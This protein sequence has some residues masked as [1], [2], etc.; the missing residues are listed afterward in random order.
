MT[1]NPANVFGPV[2]ADQSATAIIEPRALIRS[3]TCWMIPPSS[4][5]KLHLKF[6]RRADRR[7]CAP[8]QPDVTA[9]YTCSNTP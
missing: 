8:R 6:A 3:P 7:G 9:A 1:F 4:Y 5:G 2:L